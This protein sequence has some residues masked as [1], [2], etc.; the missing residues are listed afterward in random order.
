MTKFATRDCSCTH[1]TYTGQKRPVECPHG[2]RFQTE[3]ELT[4]KLRAPLRP[5]SEKRQAE[6]AAGTRRRSHGSTLSQGKGFEASPAQRKKVKGTVCVGC[7]REAS[8]D[9][10]VAID[11]AHIWPQGKGGCEHPDCV[12]GLCRGYDYSCHRLFDEGKLDLL[13][14]VSENPETFADEVTHPLLHHGVTLIELVRRLAGNRQELVWVERD[15]HH[16][17]LHP[18]PTTEGLVAAPE[19]VQ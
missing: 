4:P 3:A 10:T 18:S 12:W 17:D 2:N 15:L 1:R 14:R 5:V 6:E 16:P 9:G 11:P 8:E 19:G 7:G 13:S